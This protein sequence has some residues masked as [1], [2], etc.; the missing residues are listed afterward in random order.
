M[1][2]KL[3]MVILMMRQYRPKVD[4]SK[5]PVNP[6]ATQN[7]TSKQS[8]AV[9]NSSQTLE[10]SERQPSANKNTGTV[11]TKDYPER[12]FCAKCCGQNRHLHHP[13][14]SENPQCKLRQK[15]GYHVFLRSHR[16]HF[17]LFTSR[18]VS[19][20]GSKEIVDRLI[21]GCRLGCDRCKQDFRTGKSNTSLKHSNE[22]IALQ[23]KSKDK[24]TSKEVAGAQ[25]QSNVN[26]GDR[27][28]R[29]DKPHG[30]KMM[31]P[32]Q[33][34]LQ[35]L[36]VSKKAG[37]PKASKQILLKEADKDSETIE[38]EEDD[39]DDESIDDNEIDDVTSDWVNASNPWG[40]ED[41]TEDDVVLFAPYQGIGH[42]DAT[43]FDS[44][45][46]A[47]HPFSGESRYCRTHHTPLQGFHALRLSRDIMCQKPWGFTTYRHDFGGACLVGDVDPAGPARTAVSRR[48]GRRGTNERT[49]PHTKN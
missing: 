22:C 15:R 23:M 35:H 1:R 25:S 48:K 18:S 39:G 43:F 34:L 9:L 26:E 4:E 19:H 8:A 17:I 7:N 10:Q 42:P 46:F 49:T 38:D 44:K 28:P 5:D 27:V 20:S 24:S 36:V 41:T 31:G 14:C 3:V 11:S 6:K 40:R 2:S 32:K 13:W 30:S 29:T 21:E 45:R 12:P 47:S 33:G 37:V 16:S